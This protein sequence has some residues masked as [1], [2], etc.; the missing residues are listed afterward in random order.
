MIND[1]ANSWKKSQS[2]VLSLTKRSARFALRRTS[3]YRRG[4]ENWSQKVKAIH[5]MP[6]PQSKEDVK[7]LLRFVQCLSRYL[8]SLSTINAPLREFEKSEVLFHWGYPQKESLEKIKQFVSQAPILQYY[9]VTKPV[10]IQCDASGKGLGAV[11]LQDSK[12]VCYASQALADT[13]TRYAPIETEMKAVVFACCK[14]H[15]YNYGRSV[16][17]ETDHK[18]LQAISTKPLLQLPLRLQK[19]ILNV[20]GY[21]GEIRYIPGRKQVPTDTLSRASVQ[22]TDSGAFEAFQEINM[23]LSVLEERYEEFQKETKTDLQAVVTM[24]TSGWPDKKPQVPI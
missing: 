24:V 13:E 11:L 4:L 20:R 23:A 8:P 3:P 2:K 6:G 19:M 1:C 9:D 14:F 15:P 7:W 10:T 22:N 12:T 5:E 18:P 21:N 17:V 16:I